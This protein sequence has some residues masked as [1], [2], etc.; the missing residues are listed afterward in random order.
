MDDEQTGKND[1]L[2]V[3]G[4]VDRCRLAWG[5]FLL[6]VRPRQM[7][8]LLITFAILVV[9][10]SV[11]LI[12]FSKSNDGLTF[13]NGLYIP[14]ELK[15]DLIEGR[16]RFELVAAPGSREF[17][18][19]R[20]TGTAGING[21][22]LG[23]TIRV[24]RGDRVDFT[25]VNRL[26]EM[27]TMHWHGMHV[28][29]RMDGTPHQEIRPG[30]SWTASFQVDQEAASL[31]YHPHPHGYTGAHA[32]LGIAGMLLVDDPNSH[33][34]DIPKTY[35]VDDFPLVVQDR[36]FDGRG[37]FR[38]RRGQGPAHGDTILINGTVD[39]HL[40][41]ES[42]MNRFRLLNGSNART[43][44]IGFDDNRQFH[45]IATDGG[46]LDQPWPTRRVILA[47][48]ERAEILADFSEGDDVVL[49][50]FAE[51]GLLETAEAFFDG[52]G[53]GHFDLL[54]IRPGPANRESH[55]LPKRLNAI[56]RIEPSSATR[57]RQ[58]QLGG[59]QRDGAG[60]PVP[61]GKGGPGR[62]IPIN[63]KLMSM[64]RIDERI[65]LGD[66]E[67]WEINNR[68]GQMHPFHVHLVQFQ[69]LDRNGQPPV[70]PELGW[71]D[72]VRVPANESVRFIAKFAKYAD[73]E[74]PY[75][76]HCHLME[77][78]DR[79]MMGQ[80]LVV[81][82][83]ANLGMLQGQPNVLL[84]ITG[85]YCS[86]CYEQVE[87]FD[88][89]LAT[90]DVELIVVSPEDESESGLSLNGT[91]ISDTNRKWAGWFGMA[92]GDISHGTLLL[93]A[94]GKEI[95]RSVGHEPYM[96]AEALIRRVGKLRPTE[97]TARRQPTNSGG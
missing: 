90:Q 81:E 40:K 47:P 91:M 62:G 25:V 92:H 78:E 39:P 33:N 34:Q 1:S 13:R 35:G 46:F 22:Y 31:W 50:S 30:D 14:E 37:Q 56:S 49:K 27:T 58:F 95:W 65:R 83:P 85:L 18:P 28:P 41:V 51:A 64:H 74:V 21:P 11:W 72:T 94:K 54:K 93:D 82:E 55:P 96:D 29:A 87:R 9:I 6:F 44:H 66:T 16:K 26:A 3:T 89:A 4:F 2:R 76:F 59:P 8:H 23:P 84:F 38:Y 7:R 17:L 97:Q 63:G 10:F 15:G 43:Y 52:E 53:N 68:S 42:R 86:H 48:G 88:R 12:F 75:M 60:R 5:V 80:F 71:K 73:P 45:Q 70:G 79:G 61:K 57:T 67:I 32:Y 24:N 69:I 19:G 20:S 77:H 36:E